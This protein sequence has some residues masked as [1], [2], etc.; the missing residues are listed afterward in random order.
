M[1]VWSCFR[2]DVYIVIRF[3]VG[4]FCLREEVFGSLVNLGYVRKVG[5]GRGEKNESIILRSCFYL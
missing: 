5:V 3:F 2:L 1:L 4:D